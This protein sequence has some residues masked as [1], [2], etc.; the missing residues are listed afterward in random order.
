[1]RVDAEVVVALA[2]DGPGERLEPLLLRG[3]T[4]RV[5][6][7][8]VAPVQPDLGA[9]VEQRLDEA[10]PQAARMPPAR[11]RRAG[12]A[13]LGDHEERRAVA[14]R[15]RSSATICSKLQFGSV[16]RSR[17]SGAARARGLAQRGA[18]DA[19]A[20]RRA[21]AAQPH[22]A[23]RS[24]SSATGMSTSC[25]SATAKRA[26]PSRGGSTPSR[27]AAARA[28]GRAGRGTTHEARK[29]AVLVAR[30]RPASPRPARDGRTPRRDRRLP[31]ARRAR[32]A[33]T[34]P[35]SYGRSS[36]KPASRAPIVSSTQRARRSTS[37]GNH[38]KPPRTTRAAWTN[39]GLGSSRAK[40]ASTYGG[41]APRALA[42]ASA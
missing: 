2:G 8:G 4:D 3:E 21:S 27:R 39:A 32:P 31:A 40:T 41:A 29:P 23:A 10:R 6:G 36:P 13:W 35:A 16:P 5:V 14:P 11:R 19:P 15:R 28:A 34:P 25:V 42:A 18:R 9:G 17:C 7:G 38:R 20:E 30:R 24:A 37:C 12:R 22:R 33:P 26:P 1:M